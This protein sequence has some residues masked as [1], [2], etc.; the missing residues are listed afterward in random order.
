LPLPVTDRSNK[1][2]RTVRALLAHGRKFQADY[3]PAWMA[4]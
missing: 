2:V 3:M 4:A 1:N